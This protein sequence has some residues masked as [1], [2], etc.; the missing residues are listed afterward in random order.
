MTAIAVGMVM[1]RWIFGYLLSIFSVASLNLI[2]AP[3]GSQLGLK[4]MQFL[5]V[6]PVIGQKVVPLMTAWRLP[7][8]GFQPRPDFQPPADFQPPPL[9]LPAP[10]NEGPIFSFA[11]PVPFFNWTLSP[12][13]FTLILQAGLIVT[14]ATMAVRRWEKADKHS[15][16]KLYA[17][18]VLA[19]FIF[20]VVG[21][22]WPIITGQYLPFSI[23]GNNN[24]DQLSDYI[25]IGLPLVYS[26]AVV[27]LCAF[28][29]ANSIPAHHAYLRGVRRAR[30]LERKAALPWDDDSASI[31]FMS[32]FVLLTLIGFWILDREMTAA[33]F[34][35]FLAGTDYA[36]WRLPLVLG[37]VLFSMLLNLQVIE[38][39]GA[40]L[41][42][43]LIWMLPILTAIVA[44]AA[45]ENLT[46]LQTI[47]A[48]LSPLATLLMA[49]LSPLQSTVPVDAPNEFAVINSGVQTGI[50]FL[51]AQIALLAIRWRYLR[52]TL[53]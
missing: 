5:S 37:L 44:T 28:L 16:S 53:Q 13:L 2:L 49:G 12:F 18:S 38:Q 35:D 27:M 42:I 46:R 1:K 14:F 24:L 31:S 30:K 11:D 45:M 26:L 50:A 52:T 10:L 41:S 9:P 40:V 25:A 33:G 17:L 6:F 47:L 22:L 15:L 3:L 29:F 32:L 21:N 36:H 34:T 7:P 39:R 43:L 23:L 19:A 4:F 48:S 20:L 8:P 51:I